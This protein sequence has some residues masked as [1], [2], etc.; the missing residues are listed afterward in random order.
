MWQQLVIRCPRDEGGDEKNTRDFQVQDGVNTDILVRENKRETM[1]K[2]HHYRL[3][4]H[5]NQDLNYN[6]VQQKR[7]DRLNRC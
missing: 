5:W 6:G 2:C 1:K 7:Q 4:Q 3:S